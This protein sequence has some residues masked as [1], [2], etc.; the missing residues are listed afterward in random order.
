MK[1]LLDTNVLSEIRKP[2]HVADSTVRAWFSGLNAETLWVSVI[3]VLEIELGIARIERRDP[4]QAQRLQSWLEDDLLEV[5]EYRILA[6]DLPVARAAARLH[7]PDP[8]SERDALI[9]ATALVNGCTIATRNVKDFNG[10][11]TKLIN[12]WLLQSTT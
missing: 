1:Y 3:S 10:M 5:F 8:K 11:G 12:P 9:G 2:A 6:V 4:T 7:V